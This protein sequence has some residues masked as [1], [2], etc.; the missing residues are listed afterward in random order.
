M[1]RFRLVLEALQ[2]NESIFFG[3]HLDKN[4]IRAEDDEWFES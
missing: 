3:N 2:P 4:Y 1:M